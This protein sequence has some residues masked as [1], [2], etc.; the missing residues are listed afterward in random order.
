MFNRNSPLYRVHKHTE[1]AAQSSEMDVEEPPFASE[2]AS[3]PDFGDEPHHLFHR[4]EG[5]A[6][7]GHGNLDPKAL[8]DCVKIQLHGAGQC[9]RRISVV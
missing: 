8:G 4:H 9:G 5:S 7:V 2:A 6:C 1:R 3:E